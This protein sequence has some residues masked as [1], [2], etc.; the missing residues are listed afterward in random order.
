MASRKRTVITGVGLLSPIGEG[1]AAFGASLAAGRSGVKPIS[2]FDPSALSC[3]IGGQIDGFDAKG[4]MDKKD[5]KSL[6][7]MAR[8]IQLGVAAS[9]LAIK[10]SGLSIPK[11]GEPLEAG[12]QDPTRVGIDFGASLIASDLDEMAPGAA[13]SVHG[14]PGEVDM[15]LWGG[16]GLAAMPPLWMLKYLPNMPACHV[17]IL[18]NLQGPSNTVT[19]NDVAGL[20]GMAEGARIIER[21]AA[22]VMLTGGSDSRI[23]LLSMTRLTMFHKFSQ[24]NDEPT[25]A[26]RPFDAGR[27]G[28][29][30]GEG[31]TVLVLEE[32]DHAKKRG[33]KI[34]AEIVGFG[35]AHDRN[36]DGKGIA[37][38]IQ[39]ALKAAGVTADQLDHVNA[40]GYGHP[41]YD[42][43]EA[44]G[45]KQAFGAK[46]P[47][48]VAYKGF[49]GN[50]GAAASSTELA[51][52]LFALESG[53]LPP[54]L[55]CEQPDPAL[56]LPVATKARPMEKDCFLKVSFSDMGQCAACVV[57]RYAA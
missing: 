5:R 37:R 7:M 6:K 55:N 22:D 17:S 51:A 19:E 12:R 33:A 44:A 31:S 29:I 43:Q 25:K 15:Q 38:A 30:F 48:V 53:T 21:G 56:G 4:Y 49:F 45:L 11:D 14:A 18:H 39:A 10:D 47:P 34:Y 27:D 32:L 13:E 9:A 8:S 24:R 54:T 41:D 57:R 36:R 35:S 1:L 28:L 20:L 2:L 46:I 42:Q 40:Q 16:K 52:S 23:N 3:R 50:M 26:C